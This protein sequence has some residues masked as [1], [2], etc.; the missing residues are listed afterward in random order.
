M[1]EPL[2]R[3]QNLKV[4]LGRQM[5]Y[6]GFNAD[7]PARGVTG[8]IG[9]NGC[10]KSTLLRC[11]AG[12]L[13]PLSGEVLLA[14]QTV[15][16][17]PPQERARRLAFLPQEPASLPDMTVEGLVAKGRTPW[18]RAFM[19]LSAGDR[20]AMARAMEATDLA[21]LEQR[22]LADLSGG[23]RQR[24]WL[25]MALAQETPVI[26]LDE[27]TSYL[28]LPHQLRLLHL[29]RGLAQD[30]GRQVVMVLHDLTLAARFCDHILGLNA[31][32]MVCEGPPE[33]AVTPASVAA[34]YGLRAEVRPDPV[35]GRPV[36]YPLE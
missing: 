27:P 18:R 33:Q 4:R 11:L 13:S 12:V 22:R 35:F 8:I 34:L 19:P 21:G 3:V 2:F 23:Q 1:S 32:R 6:D 16:A 17:L 9:P 30:H 29:L 10:G 20:A 24:V 26:L 15:N 36:V 31:G 25:A 28:D 14:G 7:L 5:I